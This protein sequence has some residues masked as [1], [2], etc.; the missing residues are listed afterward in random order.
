MMN[1]DE[2]FALFYRTRT[3]D[4]PPSTFRME[5]STISPERLSGGCLLYRLP[6]PAGEMWDT[7]K[8]RARQRNL[9]DH[10]DDHP[11]RMLLS[12]VGEETSDGA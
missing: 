3:I 6:H 1:P 11:A 5:V 8:G 4:E 2:Y 7:H 9:A 10:R 12:R